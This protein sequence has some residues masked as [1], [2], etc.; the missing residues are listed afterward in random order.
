MS[1]LEPLSEGLDA[2]LRKLG[3]PSPHDGARLIDEWRE[4]AGEPWASRA[5]PVGITRGELLLEVP[6]G[7]SATLLQYQTRALIDRLAERLGTQLVRDVRIRVE[8][9]KKKR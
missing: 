5:R 7:A 1:D 6:D 9:P 4:L 8:N 2:L 3:V